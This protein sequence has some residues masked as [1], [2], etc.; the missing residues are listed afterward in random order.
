MEVYVL[1]AGLKQVC[2]L[3]LSEPD[4]LSVQSYLKVESGILVDE[5]L[6]RR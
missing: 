1:G 3:L 4:G 6:P 2:H 5:D